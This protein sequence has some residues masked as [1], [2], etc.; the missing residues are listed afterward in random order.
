MPTFV[1]A[2]EP[3][4]LRCRLALQHPSI[5]AAEHPHMPPHT[6]TPLLPSLQGEMAAMFLRHEGFLGAV[7]AFMKLQALQGPHDRDARKVRSA[8]GRGDLHEATW[9]RAWYRCACCKVQC[10]VCHFGLS[11]ACPSRPCMPS[12]DAHSRPSPPPPLSRCAPALW[13]ASAWAP[14]SW[15]ARCAAPPSQVRASGG[16]GVLVLHGELLLRFATCSRHE[17]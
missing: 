15:A 13:S 6:H 7:G 17:R 14:P 1:L 5:T 16:N 4:M 12:H 10:I 9:Y 3:S 11:S 8:C 2:N